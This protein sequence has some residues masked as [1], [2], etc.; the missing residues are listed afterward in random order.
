MKERATALMH[1]RSAGFLIVLGIV[2]GAFGAH[3]LE[4]VLDERGMASFET[5]SRY[6]L[7]MGAALTGAWATGE[8]RGLAWVQCGAWLFSVSIFVLVADRYWSWGYSDV[9]GPVTPL[10]GTLMIV[11]WLL[12]MIRFG[13]RG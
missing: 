8:H 2:A 11:G 1:I 13:K 5:A 7:L 6:A 4:G 12:W 10:G 9:W 3:A